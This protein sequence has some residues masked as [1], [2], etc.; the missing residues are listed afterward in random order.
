[1]WV[2]AT[3]SELVMAFE[4]VSTSNRDVYVYFNTNDMIGTS[5]GFNGIHYL[6]FGAEHVLIITGSGASM[7]ANGLTGW[8][9]VPSG[10]ISINVLL[11]ISTSIRTWNWR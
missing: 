4:G 8:T 7:Y 10:A 9:A 1:M 2:Y 3:T 6:P 5:T 11:S